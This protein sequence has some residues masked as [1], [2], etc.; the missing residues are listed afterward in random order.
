MTNKS[1]KSKNGIKFGEP[2]M[3]FGV[4]F[5][6]GLCAALF[7]RLAPMIAQSADVNI[8]LLHMDY[9]IVALV[10]SAIIGMVIMWFYWG[11]E[12][13]PQTLFMVALGIPSL[14]SSSLNMNDSTKT[15]AQQQQVRQQLEV[16]LQ[17]SSSIETLNNDDAPEKIKDE[18]S[19]L[20]HDL[21]DYLGIA[22]A[23][24]GS[25]DTDKTDFNPGIQTQTGRDAYVVVLAKAPRA[26]DL[27]SPK[28]QYESLNIEGVKIIETERGFYLVAG[29]RH[30]TRLGA[31][32]EALDIK[33]KAGSNKS[34][35]LLKVE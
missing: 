6:A 11:T 22:R 20:R 2:W 23:H 8:K 4:G 3:L 14:L 10:F 5:T 13:K 35:K 31:L 1:T 16:K 29:K 26:Q 15:I 7:P 28:R 21:G 33:E 18:V 27:A 30:R 32:T 12:H 34:I 24:A 25:N 19:S 9:L 17:R